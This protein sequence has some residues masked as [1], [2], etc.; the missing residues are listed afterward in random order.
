MGYLR[1]EMKSTLKRVMSK[2]IKMEC[3][4]KATDITKVDYTSKINQHDNSNIAV[5]RGARL[6]LEE[7]VDLP[8]EILQRFF[9]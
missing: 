5:G 8:E 3:I 2:F 6:Y 1:Q 7:N 4:T 9:G